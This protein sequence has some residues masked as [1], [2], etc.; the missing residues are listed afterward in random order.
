[1]L[2]LPRNGLCDPLP[3]EPT[4]GIA[5][6]QQPNARNVHLSKV[7]DEGADV[8]WVD[9][10]CGD[11]RVWR[12]KG[13]EGAGCIGGVDAGNEAV[14]LVDVSDVLICCR[15]DGG[16]YLCVVSSRTVVERY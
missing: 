14:G 3:I 13:G 6:A 4:P 9:S 7:S 15:G 8:E 10:A 1:M 2:L 5:Q 16:M 11:G 12:E